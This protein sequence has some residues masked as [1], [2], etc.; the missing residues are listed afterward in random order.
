MVGPLGKYRLGS[1]HS[2]TRACKHKRT[3]AGDADWTGDGRAVVR[4]IS[5]EQRHVHRQ[6]NQRTWTQSAARSLDWLWNGGRALL[7]RQSGL[8]GDA[9]M[10]SVSGS[11]KTSEHR[12]H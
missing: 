3:L 11:T 4:S 9:A 5:L 1:G 6:R 12:G 8:C 7:A 2:A 10:V